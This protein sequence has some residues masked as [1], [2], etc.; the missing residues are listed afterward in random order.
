MSK[1]ELLDTIVKALNDTA[2][3][4]LLVPTLLVFGVMPRIPLTPTDLPSQVEHLIDS[5]DHA[6]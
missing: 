2:E 6:K 5:W 4:E 3:P 1:R